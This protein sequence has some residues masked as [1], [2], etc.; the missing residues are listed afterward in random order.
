MLAAKGVECAAIVPREGE[1]CERLRARS[2]PVCVIPY[3]AW[4]GPWIPWRQRIPRIWE[5]LVAAVRAARQVRRWQADIVYTNTMCICV[6]AL[7]ARW[8]GRPHVWHI[9]EFGREDHGLSFLFGEER[10]LRWAAGMADVF[11]ANSQA[12]KDYYARHIPADKIQVVYQGVKDA[13]PAGIPPRDPTGPFRCVMVGAVHEGKRQM[14]AVEAVLTL[15]AE[16]FDVTLTIVGGPG[17][18]GYF[19]EVQRRVAES[20]YSEKI[21]MVGRV[22]D[23]SPYLV[24]AD[25]LLMCSQKEAFGRVTVEG[26]LAGLPVIGTRSGGTPE[27]VE[28]GLCGLLYT[29]GDVGQMARHVRWLMEHPAEAKTMGRRGRERALGRFGMD[30][31]GES[32]FKALASVAD[33]RTRKAA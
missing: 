2:I 24:N 28:D 33:A 30:Q 21:T 7:A 27:I 18:E 1:M 13:C 23:A 11:I 15:L 6:G 17:S 12:V 5:H 31:Y 19:R 22:D 4:L 3:G 20:A 10:S 8:A 9:R 25:V 26:M 14:D 16:R 32:I 29:P